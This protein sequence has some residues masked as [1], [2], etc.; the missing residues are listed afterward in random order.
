M[1]NYTK[2]KTKAGFLLLDRFTVNVKRKGQTT[3]GLFADAAQS[4]P[5]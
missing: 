3:A 5:A 1:E 2:W 4:P